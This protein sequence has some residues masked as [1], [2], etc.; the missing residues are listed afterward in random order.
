MGWTKLGQQRYCQGST[1]P[2]A[3]T[4][5]HFR[6]QITNLE[7]ISGHT[8]VLPLNWAP[9]SREQLASRFIVPPPAPQHNPYESTGSYSSAR[10]RAQHPKNLPETLAPTAR[11]RLASRFIVPPSTPQCISLALPLSSGTYFSGR[12]SGN[13]PEN[14]LANW[15]VFQKYHLT[16]AQQ[17]FTTPR[18]FDH[19]Q[20]A[21]HASPTTSRKCSRRLR[22]HTADEAP[23]KR[24]AHTPQQIVGIGEPSLLFVLRQAA[25]DV[26][27]VKIP[28]ATSK[29]RNECLCEGKAGWCAAALRL[30]QKVAAE[31]KEWDLMDT[32]LTDAKVAC[33]DRIKSAANL[34]PFLPPKFVQSALE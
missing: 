17:P 30:V 3:P 16:S 23:N 20:A 4:S 26:G 25:L 34:A 7:A 5:A 18:V 1:T 28:I 2:A 31:R 11:D 27:P 22:E 12:F 14:C 15:R 29:L 33:A 21:K 8:A 9:T 32:L 6:Q 13:H 24:A 19:Q 10:F